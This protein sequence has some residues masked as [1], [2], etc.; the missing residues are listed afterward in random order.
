M[1]IV[2]MAT[3]F[4]RSTPCELFRFGSV[5]VTRG[6]CGSMTLPAVLHA[7]LREILILEKIRCRGNVCGT[8]VP[9]RIEIIV[10]YGVEAPSCWI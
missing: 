5:L 3:E 4:P 9:D 1:F 7:L 2:A 10:V 8:E 6:L